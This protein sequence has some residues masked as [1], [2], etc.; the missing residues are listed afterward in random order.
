M[1]SAWNL[2]QTQDAAAIQ[3]NLL[4]RNADNRLGGGV[5]DWE[6][7]RMK[8]AERCA[9]FGVTVETEPGSADFV[10]TL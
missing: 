5:S 9:A 8:F 1:H 4:P 6:V 7:L 10:I 3:T 2:A